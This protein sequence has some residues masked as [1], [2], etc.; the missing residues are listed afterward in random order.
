MEYR[1]E[2]REPRFVRLTGR[3]GARLLIARHWIS[4]IEELRDKEMTLV[5]VVGDGA[6]QT[7]VVIERF[8]DLEKELGP[9]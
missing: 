3:D 5:R 9:A 7:F 8:K 6:V 2:Y 4:A 1:V